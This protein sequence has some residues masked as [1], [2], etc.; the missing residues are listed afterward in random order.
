MIAVHPGATT[1]FALICLSNPVRPAERGRVH[2]T[3]ERLLP[4]LG[5]KTLIKLRSPTTG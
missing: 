3:T 4:R 1:A 2:T 5:A